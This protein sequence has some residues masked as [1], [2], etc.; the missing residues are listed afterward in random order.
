[1]SFDDTKTG[2]QEDSL[3]RQAAKAAKEAAKKSEYNKDSYKDKDSVVR[4]ARCLYTCVSVSALLG[5]FLG[6][7][8]GLAVQT[9]FLAYCFPECPPAN[10][11]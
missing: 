3:N 1:L 8:G 10:S 11:V 4:R 7:L 2:R 6:G 5:G 9:V